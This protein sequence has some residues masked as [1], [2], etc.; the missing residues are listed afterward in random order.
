M[1]SSL[2]PQR[3]L[4]A[5]LLIVEDDV[6][7][8][9]NMQRYFSPF[10]KTIW[11][12]DTAANA[13][14]IYE[15]HT[16]S[17]VISDIELPYGNGIDLIQKIR[18]KDATFPI[19]IVTAFPKETYLLDA[20]LLKLEDFVIKPLTSSKLQSIVETCYKL[21]FKEELCLDAHAHVYYSYAKKIISSPEESITLTHLEITIFEA[22]LKSRNSIL[23]YEELERLLALENSFSRNSLR[24][25]IARLRKKHSSICIENHVHEG[26]VL[27]C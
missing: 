20:I 4:D 15:T 7:A 9:S 14:D 12:C 26:Y 3:R 24:V 23:S 11:V 27:R 19:F 13:W 16:P 5:T 17:V 2:I 22:L 21:F 1:L 8:S 18:K 25:L 6:V 10:F